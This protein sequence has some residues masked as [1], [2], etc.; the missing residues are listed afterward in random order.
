LVIFERPSPNIDRYSPDVGRF[1]FD[2]DRYS[3]DVARFPVDF[4][5]F[6]SDI[7]PNLSDSDRYPAD[8]SSFFPDVNRFSTEMD[9]SRAKTGLARDNFEY[10]VIYGCKI[11]GKDVYFTYQKVQSE[12]TI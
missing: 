1:L 8:V 6:L 9:N 5:R 4:G 10:D 3:P 11:N 2:F 12:R 7:A